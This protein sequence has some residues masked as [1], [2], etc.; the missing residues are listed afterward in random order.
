MLPNSRILKHRERNAVPLGILQQFKSNAPMSAL[1]TS[2][3][4]VPQ[5]HE[6]GY[7]DDHCSE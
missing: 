2:G 3:H 4:I 7:A 6:N 5:A 1:K